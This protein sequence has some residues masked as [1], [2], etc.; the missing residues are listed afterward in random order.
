MRPKVASRIDKVAAVLCLT[1]LGA[2]QQD[3]P[4]TSFWESQA[5]AIPW[6]IPMLIAMSGVFALGPLG[7]WSEG[8][9]IQRRTNLQRET[10][11]EFGRILT[12]ARGVKEDLPL[13]DVGLHLWQV[14]W[15]TRYWVVP[16]RYLRRVSTYRI[17]GSLVLRDFTP[18]KGEGV[19]GQCWKHN[20]EV[21]YDVAAIKAAAP[22]IAA[23]EQL[24][25]SQPDEVMGLDWNSFQP[26]SHRESVFAS[27]IRN[28]R[29]R[30]TGCVSLDF[31]SDH[32]A[33]K[34]TEI[35]EILNEIAAKMSTHEFEEM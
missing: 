5:D 3:F 1:P 26:V 20:C 19:V 15:R 25:Q 18:T 23:Y 34:S 9:L 24:R 11:V 14:R 33:M 10:L 7:A 32:Q 28:S 27:P 21:D 17:G 8:G 16:E 2:E 31:A 13:S 30:V 22:D 35:P 6:L 29:Q 4:S 12:I